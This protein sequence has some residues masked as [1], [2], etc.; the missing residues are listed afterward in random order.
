MTVRIHQVTGSLHS[1]ED[2]SPTFE[3]AERRARKLARYARRLGFDVVSDNVDRGEPGDRIS[4]CLEDG[5]SS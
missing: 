3:E 1:D 2:P 4:P 5:S